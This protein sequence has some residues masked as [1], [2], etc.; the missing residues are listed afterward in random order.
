MV[1]GDQV[2][3]KFQPRRLDDLKP[4]AARFVG[5]SGIFEALWVIE[6]GYQY[7]GEW[8]MRMP[9]DWDGQTWVWVPSGDLDFSEVM[10]G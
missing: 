8:A 7:A 5:R 6:D 10:R 2:S 1:S 9:P 3:A 4:D